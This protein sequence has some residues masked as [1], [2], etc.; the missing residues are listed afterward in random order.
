MQVANAEKAQQNLAVSIR[1]DINL[2]NT[3]EFNDITLFNRRYEFSKTNLLAY[4][5]SI[6]A[7]FFCSPMPIPIQ[8]INVT[9]GDNFTDCDLQPV[10][11]QLITD[12][13]PTAFQNRL[14]ERVKYYYLAVRMIVR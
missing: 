8:Q 1:N 11:A 2:F 6:P 13:Q 10:V 7:S 14:T 4:N 3:I 9:I 5:S 12:F